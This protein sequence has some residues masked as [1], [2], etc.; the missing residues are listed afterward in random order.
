[1]FDQGRLKYLKQEEIDYQK[2]DDCISR[3]PN[4]RVYAASWFLDRTAKMW[5]A[6]VWGDYEFVMPLPFRRKL[7]IS[8]LYQPIYC[9]QLGI[10]PAPPEPVAHEFIIALYRKFKYSDIQLNALDLPVTTGNEIRFSGRKNY[11]LHLETDYKNIYAG[12]TT[13]TRRNIAKAAGK[14]LE[15]SDG[16]ALEEYLEFKRNNLI[17]KLPESGFQK[18]K[19]IMAYSLHHGFGKIS[20]VY[21]SENTLCAAACFC[22]WKNRL[23]YLNAV[24]DNEGKENRAMFFLIDHF[25]KSTAGKNLTLDFEGSMLPGVARFFAGFGAAPEMYYQLSFN[26]LPFPVNLIKK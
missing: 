2:Y 23:V 20:G 1:M 15:Y 22:R 19:S 16:V 7:G 26:R 17:V 24:S 12:Y 25:I 10:F 14:N 6:L 5:D 9:Q 13:N 3:A 11:L 21:S 4:S 18:L 8:Y